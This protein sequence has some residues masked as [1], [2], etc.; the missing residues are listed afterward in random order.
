[1]PGSWWVGGVLIALSVRASRLPEIKV[2]IS[3]TANTI[4]K[5][6]P[7]QPMTSTLP[8]LCSVL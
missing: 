7:A 2:L 6:V 5:S 8:P 4:R 1:M 3:A